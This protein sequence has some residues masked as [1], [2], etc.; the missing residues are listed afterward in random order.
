MCFDVSLNAGASDTGLITCTDGNVDAHETPWMVDVVGFPA[1]SFRVTVML[2][3]APPG[4]VT[5]THASVLMAGT[6]AVP[7]QLAEPASAT[8]RLL[9]AAPSEAG[10]LAASVDAV[11]AQT[12]KR[13][14]LS[15]SVGPKNCPSAGCVTVRSGAVVSTG[16]LVRGELPLT[17]TAFLHVA[18]TW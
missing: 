15:R 14:W 10:R 8:H 4:Q 11:R 6:D 5:G 9:T 17:P 18:I 12:L 13:P 7:T 2:N 16:K 3:G 1:A